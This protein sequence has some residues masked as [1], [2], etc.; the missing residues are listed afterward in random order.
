MIR[1]R[2]FDKALLPTPA[3]YLESRGL[4]P[5]AVRGPWAAIRCP[6]HK[7]GSE[8]NPSLRVSLEDGH[9]RCMAC[10]IKGGDV[11]ALHRAITGLSFVEA[12]TELGAMR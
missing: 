7:Q 1:R 9:F 10:G 11:L 5:A 6:S 12:A 4:L 8:T 2:V 3:R